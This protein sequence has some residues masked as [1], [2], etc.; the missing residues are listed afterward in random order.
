MLGSV[1]VIGEEEGDERT[2]EREGWGIKESLP[3]SRR[4]FSSPYPGQ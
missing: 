1:T 4:G 3:L 2:E